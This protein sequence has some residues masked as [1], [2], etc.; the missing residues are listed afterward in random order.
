MRVIY[1]ITASQNNV[2]KL[3][4]LEVRRSSIRL[5]NFVNFVFTSQ[6]ENRAEN[7]LVCQRDHLPPLVKNSRSFTDSKGSFLGCE[8][9]VVALSSSPAD[10]GGGSGSNCGT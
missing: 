7:S 6:S 5:Q 2:R 3:L 9:G 10:D 1:T 4:Q 8:D